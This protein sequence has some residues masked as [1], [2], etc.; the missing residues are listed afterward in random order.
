MKIDLNKRKLVEF[1]EK[2]S[3]P[4]KE[5]A[6]DFV[7]W[8]WI[9]KES[10]FLEQ[11]KTPDWLKKLYFSFAETRKL[12]KKISSKQID[13]DITLAIKEVRGKNA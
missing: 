3:P 6:L 2:L 5:E 13:S 1:Y 11:R 4:K 7:K 8:L 10:K 9:S 12:A